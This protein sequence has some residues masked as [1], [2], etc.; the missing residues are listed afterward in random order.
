MKIYTIAGAPALASSAAACLLLLE[1]LGVAYEKVSLDFA[2]GEHKSEAYTK[3]NPNGKI[4]C[5]DDNG[6]VLWE[7]M[8][9][10][11]YLALKYSPGLLGIEVQD[12]GL[13]SQ[14]NH[15]SVSEYRAPIVSIFMDSRKPE[16]QR[17]PSVVEASMKK[18]AAMNELLDKALEGKEFLVGNYF[19]L[20]DLHIGYAVAMTSRLNM[21]LSAYKNLAP[22]VGRF[23][24]RASFQ[25]LSKA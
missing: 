21:D 3:L 14:W 16:D 23:T 6:F 17:N 1:D 2:K 11:N 25:K 13:V 24:A 8:A 9:I 10:N 4:P 12:K 20:A 5:L 7:S 15:W 18:I 22:Y 19:T